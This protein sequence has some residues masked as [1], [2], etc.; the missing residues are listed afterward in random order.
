MATPDPH[1]TTKI[2]PSRVNRAVL[3]PRVLEAVAGALASVLAAAD[4][5]AD[6]TAQLADDV[7]LLDLEETAEIFRVSRMTVMRMADEGRLP[8]VVVRRGRVQKVRRIPRAFV[9]RMVADATAGVEVDLEDC[10]AARLAEHAQGQ[11]GQAAPEERPDPEA[12]QRYD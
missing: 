4:T 6:Q 7:S 2:I 5:Q 3:P 10:A 9:E 12:S 11:K 1:E 8:S